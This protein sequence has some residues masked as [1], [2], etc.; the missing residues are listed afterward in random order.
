MSK[1]KFSKPQFRATPKPCAY[2]G[3]PSS[4]KDHVIPRS[5][6]DD[7]GGDHKITVRVCN[8]CNQRK[9]KYDEA[10]RDVLAVDMRTQAFPLA[11]TQFWGPFARSVFRHQSELARRIVEESVEVEH[12]SPGGIFLG[13]RTVVDADEEMTQ[14]MGYIVRGLT[15]HYLGGRVDPKAYVR[16]A[17]LGEQGVKDVAETMQMKGSITVGRLGDGVAEWGFQYADANRSIWLVCFYQSMF[18]LVTVE[19]PIVEIGEGDA[20]T[21]TAA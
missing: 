18:F 17:L 3:A 6:F 12:I 20:E 11:Q 14:E 9:K 8:T 2:C 19:P 15:A 5:I 10:L 16:V 21:E 7:A 13:L 1:K 4:T